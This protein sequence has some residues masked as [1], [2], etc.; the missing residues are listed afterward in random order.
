MYMRR[1]RVSSLG[2][3]PATLATSTTAAVVALVA[4][5]LGLLPHADAAGHEATPAAADAVPVELALVATPSPARAVVTDVLGADVRWG[6]K[7]QVPFGCDVSVPVLSG[8][9][10][11]VAVH[12]YGPGLGAVVMDQIARCGARTSVAGARAVAIKLPDGLLTAWTRGDVLVTVAAR[13][14]AGQQGEELDAALQAALAGVCDNLAPVK[15]DATRNPTQVGYAQFSQQRTV[16]A[17]ILDSPDVGA[18]ELPAAAP[19]PAT[20]AV[21]SGLEGPALPAVLT[22]PV[23]PVWP[24]AAPVE[25]SFAVPVADRTGPGCGWAFTTAAAPEVDQH[26]LNGAT[27]AATTAAR[28]ALGAEQQVWLEAAQGYPAAA[29]TY[30]AELT[31]WTGYLDQ[32]ATTVKLWDTQSALLSAYARAT[33]ARAAQVAALATFTT[34]HAAAATAF[35]VAAASCRAVPV[36]DLVTANPAPPPEVQAAPAAVAACPAARPAVLDAAPPVVGVEPVLPALWT[37]E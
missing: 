21:P 18:S 11:T 30:T 35:E 17:A 24:G 12:V 33:S 15:G 22:Q 2:V 9:V 3:R 32:V 29:A 5:A 27:V 16:T 7:I 36:A 37:S 25:A 26:A 10:G 19:K 34:E 6:A 4:G 14:H 20:P 23:T 13:G 28:A 1:K 31:A 8:E